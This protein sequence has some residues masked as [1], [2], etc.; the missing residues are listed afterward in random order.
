MRGHNIFEDEDHYFLIMELVSGGEL[1]ESLIENGAYSEHSAACLIHDVAE[2]IHFMH[3]HRIVHA[4]IKPENLMLR[5]HSSAVFAFEVF[6]L[7]EKLK[8]I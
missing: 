3:R 5:S 7:T 4:D 2:A 6:S 8:T 1:F